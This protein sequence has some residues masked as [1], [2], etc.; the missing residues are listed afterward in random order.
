M[1]SLIQAKYYRVLLVLLLLVSLPLACQ[2]NTT[3]G[4]LPTP[5]DLTPP[6]Q[7]GTPC[8]EVD[9]NPSGFAE[10]KPV[11]IVF[12]IEN[13]L[14]NSRTWVYEAQAYEIV[15]RVLNSVAEP[16][17]SVVIFE[18]G[19]LNFSDAIAFDGRVGDVSRPNI[20]P[21]LTLIP[22]IAPT[23]TPIATSDQ[24]IFQRSTEVAATATHAVIALTATQIEALNRCGREAWEGTFSVIAT[25]WAMTRIAAKNDFDRR[26][27]NAT[28][29]I[30]VDTERYGNQVFEG[31]QHATIA[32]NSECDKNI[33]RRCL[34]VIISDLTEYRIAQP[35]Y[36]DPQI[37]FDKKVEV[38]SI[39]LNCP[40][41]YDPT[42]SS[43]VN[44]W[45]DIFSSLGAIN[46]T[47]INGDEVETKLIE[48]IRR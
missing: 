48:F 16:G 38:L 41:L 2:S 25:Q 31:L 1:V 40:V 42:C 17:D 45:Q 15:T 23:N 27:S 20:P 30:P 39:L 18:L 36:F 35:E 11:F 28:P 7:T 24:G 47:F 22:R 13:S 34:L 4:I 43:V 21:T 19:P 9:I 37:D 26:L 3:S 10:N 14:E 33:Y 29:P 44:Q 32:F 12:S 8:P 6:T 46:S 5:Y